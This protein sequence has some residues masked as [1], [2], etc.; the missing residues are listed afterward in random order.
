MNDTNVEKISQNNKTTIDH[1]HKQFIITTNS[2][3]QIY[4]CLVNFIT[5]H[6]VDQHKININ[7]DFNELVITYVRDLDDPKTP[8][9][10]I[11]EDK[12]IIIVHNNNNITCKIS[13]ISKDHG[14]HL[15]V[16]YLYC[17]KMIADSKDI[18]ENFILDADEY[19]NNIEPLSISYYDIDSKKW[20]RSGRLQQR[21]EESLVMDTTILSNLFKDIEL[22]HSKESKDDYNFFGISYK[23]NFLFYGKPGTGK[24]SLA[25][26]IASKWRKNIYIVAFDPKLTDTALL[27]AV[28]QIQDKNGILLLEDIDCAFQNRDDT[29]NSNVSYSTLFNVLDGVSS[30]KGLITIITTNF[31]DKLDKALLRPGRIDMMIEFGKAI[32]QQL[33]DLLKIYKLDFK[34]ETINKIYSICVEKDLVTATISGFLFRYRREKLNDDEYLKLFEKYIKEINPMFSKKVPDGLYG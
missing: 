18:L 13:K 11:P 33:I 19:D 14:T 27:N 7:D 21:S 29:I 8:I 5:K 3:Q 16:K 25:K 32:K 30:P 31:I 22:F 12:Q 10:H 6:Y 20:S 28:S 17:L 9:Y 24:T 26:I 1:T 2:S 23:R 34:Q 15:Y 4:S